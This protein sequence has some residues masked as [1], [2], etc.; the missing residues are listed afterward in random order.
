MSVLLIT[1][2]AMTEQVLRWRKLLLRDGKE[3]PEDVKC[4]KPGAGT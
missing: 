2:E 3:I 4:Q 1:V